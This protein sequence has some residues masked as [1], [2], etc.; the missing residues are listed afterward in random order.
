VPGTKYPDAGAVKRENSRGETATGSGADAVI[1]PSLER[2]R[3]DALLTN[4]RKET[5]LAQHSTC[6]IML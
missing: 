6:I 1:T 3:P 4:W 2:R 5:T